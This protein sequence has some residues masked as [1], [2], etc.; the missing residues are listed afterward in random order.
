MKR[1]KNKELLQN[2]NELNM[3]I[4]EMRMALL[5]KDWVGESILSSFTRVY[6]ML[7]GE[8]IVKNANRE[9]HMN[10]GNVYI[11]P[12]GMEFSYRCDAYAKKLYFHISVLMPD[13][14]DLFNRFSD[15]IV[16]KNQDIS[17]ADRML[18]EQ[19]VSNIV[20]VKAYIY[21][22]ISKCLADCETERIHSYSE[23]IRG[24]IDYIDKNLSAMLTVDELAEKMF[25]SVSKLQKSFKAEIGI[26]IGKYIDDR[27]MLVAE[28]KIRISS[29]SV[30]EISDT[31]GFCDQFYF[32]RLF[33]KKYGIAPLKY[34]KVC[35][36]GEIAA[37]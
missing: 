1:D 35:R 17:G 36:K 30:K 5:D 8:A 33:S 34:R 18:G 21:D 16:F 26:P 7:D 15:F 3:E 31:L 27:L 32:S 20:N 24:T 10:P 13:G 29:K 2:I 4:W 6:V 11:V 23:L 28:K 37:D 19:T 25:V 14:Y 22:I 12:A 9:I